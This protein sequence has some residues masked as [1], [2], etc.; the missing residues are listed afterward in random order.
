[1]H[2]LI[3]E[4]SKHCARQFMILT[5]L[6]PADSQATPVYHFKGAPY[7]T[8]FTFITMTILRVNFSTGMVY[9]DPATYR[10]RL[11]NIPHLEDAL[12]HETKILYAIEVGCR[13]N[14]ED[15]EYPEDE[16]SY[17]DHVRSIGR[18]FAHLEDA[19][20][21]AIRLFHAIFGK[22]DG[23]IV[24]TLYERQGI[25]SFKAVLFDGYV[26]IVR[27]VAVDTPLLASW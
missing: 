5:H 27:I 8:E 16:E 9:P 12:R 21:Y 17:E 25:E 19:R 6:D 10:E 18:Y 23:E 22:P 2:D 7:S 20:H 14:D 11:T 15:A 3:V 4:L 1:M 24:N 13:D 26:G